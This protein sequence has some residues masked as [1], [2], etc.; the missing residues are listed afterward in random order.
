[1]AF[2]WKRERHWLA[3]LGL[4]LAASGYVRYSTQNELTT[5]SKVLLIAGGVIFIAALALS[6]RDI[7]AFF[8]HRSSKLG[9]NTLTLTLLVL[10]VLGLLNFL[11]FR[12]HKRIDATAEQLYTLSDQSRRISRGL[13]KDVDIVRFA[14]APDPEFSDLVAEYVNIAPHIHYRQ[15][16]PEEKPEV[17]RQYNVTKMNQ[18]VVAS[19]SHNEILGGTGEQDITNALVKITRD[20]VKTVCFAGGHGERSIEST[21]PDGYATVATSLK[22]EAYQSKDINLVSAGEVPA[23]CSVLVVAGPK[24]SLFPQ[25][26]QMIAKYLDGGGKALIM[27]DP[28]VDPKLGD[29]LQS[30][31]ITLGSNV[32]IDA[33]G[34]GRMF[35][36]GPAVPLVVKYGTN[37]IT[38]N[39]EGT[40]TFFPLARTVSMTNKTKPEPDDTELL[41]TS[42]RSFT[43][44]N[45]K[46]KEITYNP[47][48][49]N[50]GPLSLGVAGERKATAS[51]AVQNTGTSAPGANAAKVARLVVIGNSSFAANQWA[52]LQRNGDLFMN[53]I[54]WLA[55]DEDL[56]SIRPKNAT[57]RRVLLTETQQREL[58]WLS[59]IFL[60]G[61]V[62][63]SG[64]MMWL[65]RR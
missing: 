13:Q 11:G 4:A 14:K 29:L 3:S 39:F 23:D 22:N 18:V 45:L 49:D 12:H 5:I 59:L 56:I 62:V 33:S 10:V 42:E 46:T 63:I 24:Q 9:T 40:M 60:P 38:R 26:S 19:G 41:L 17:A 8:T 15:V 27:V 55:Q 53:T 1:M 2:D 7:V 65:R 58:Y 50:A 30:W 21:E 25:E 47:A 35:G 64:A 51:P 44:P 34:V 37:P 28:E 36:T 31:N 54:N 20:A 16:D 52:T 32:V 43:V 48:K 61:L 6:Y 57:N